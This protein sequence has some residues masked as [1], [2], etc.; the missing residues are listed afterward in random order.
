MTTRI[1]VNGILQSDGVTLRLEKRLSLQPGR[2]SVT[3]QQTGA[4][5]G[6]T[7]LEVLENI[8]QD[9]QR[10]GHP[11]MTEE[12]MAAE[13]AQARAEDEESEDRWRQIWSQTRSPC[14][15]GG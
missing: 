3:V 2:V 13:I 9:Q 11:Q 10:R 1:T 8:H 4:E 7:M 12:E 6:P 15:N 14:Q 5:S